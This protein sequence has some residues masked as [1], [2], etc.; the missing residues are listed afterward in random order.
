MSSESKA[1]VSGQTHVFDR[2]RVHFLRFGHSS[3]DLL[4]RSPALYRSLL[5]KS[6]DEIEQL[7]QLKE[8]ELRPRE[9]YNYLFAIFDLQQCFTKQWHRD[10]VHTLEQSMLDE[11]FLR[12]FCSL[13]QE[14][15]FWKGF[16]RSENTPEYLLKYLFLYFDVLAE[17]S[18]L[19]RQN[20]RA[21]RYRHRNSPVPRKKSMSIDEALSALGVT[22][23]E[24]AQMDKKALT[25]LYRKK[26][27]TAHP[28]K[29][30][31][32]DGFISLT[33]AYKELLRTRL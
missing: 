8:Q 28:D 17:G 33:T 29:G 30:G 9:L 16:Q 26:A 20:P 2:R 1:R 7:I 31:D 32:H 19:F 3:P 5:H 14:P 6:R 11:A 24:L 23:K 12:Q 15:A 21:R 22:R 10:M 25:A 27:H 18:Y 13:D 4:D